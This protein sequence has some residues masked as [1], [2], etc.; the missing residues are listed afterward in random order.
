MKILVVY[1][2][3]LQAKKA[4]NYGIHAVGESGGELLLLQ[5]F[6]RSA[7]VDYDAGPRAED[8]AR[9]E[10]AGHLAWAMRH[11]QEEAPGLLVRIIEEEGDTVSRAVHHAATE[12]VDLLLAPPAFRVLRTTAPCAVRI[13]PGLILLPLDSSGSPAAGVGEV[14]REAT[15]TG[16]PVLLLGIVPVHLYS[17]EE[18]LELEAV[19]QETE[20]SVRRV[21]GLLAGQGIEVRDAIRSGYPDE[22]ILKA[23]EEHSAS[24]IMLPAGGVTPSELSKAASILLEEAPHQRL[25]ISLFPA[26][27]AA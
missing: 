27:G 7:F 12:H 8:A 9:A 25:V 24:L 21:K 15:L 14:V 20:A 26:A 11:L 16:S 17:R 3:T 13:I 10:R 18:K 19:R 2:G 22:E 4:L 23:A 5:V 6:D 1:D